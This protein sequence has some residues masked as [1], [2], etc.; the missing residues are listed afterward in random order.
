MR[1]PPALLI[2]AALVAPLSGC[3]SCDQVERALR[4]TENH[5]RETREELDRQIAINRGLQ[6]ELEALHAPP[7]PPGAPILPAEH[8]LPVY[9]VKSVVLGRQTGGVEGGSGVADQALQVIVE[10]RDADDQAIKVPGSLLV[11]VLEVNPEGLKRPLSAWEVPPDQLSRT[12][13]SGLLSTG[14]ALTF[15]WKVWPS[16]E[17]LRV[18]VQMRLN[19]GRVFEADRDVT[20]RLA[21]PAHRRLMR[22]AEPP[23]EQLAPPPPPPKEETLPPPRPADGPKLD[24]SAKPK[25]NQ[26]R[27]E[28]AAVPHWKDPNDPWRSAALPGPAV[29][30]QRPVARDD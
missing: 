14:Y 5:L 3:R 15:P 28:P 1:W 30:I 12:W 9:P 4:V 22:P 2:G 11:Q 20:I 27:R 17:K 25:F 19:D 8:P 6:G 18:V 23:P 29:Q 7:P 16:A 13:R 21:A 26:V 24:T 10:P